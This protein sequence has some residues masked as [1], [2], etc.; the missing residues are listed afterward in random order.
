MYSYPDFLKIHI[1]NYL[2]NPRENKDST[3]DPN[4]TLFVS[5]LSFSAREK[6]LKR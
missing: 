5:K 6:H 2:G 3:S 1:I 4:K